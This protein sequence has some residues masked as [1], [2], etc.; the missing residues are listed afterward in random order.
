M[1]RTPKDP[2]KGLDRDTL[3]LPELGG[4]SENARKN[5]LGFEQLK[6]ACLWTQGT[7]IGMSHQPPMTQEKIHMLHSRVALVQQV[8]SFPMLM[9]I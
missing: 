5:Q 4:S 6:E 8:V 3:K 9:I 2:R 7:K 1:R